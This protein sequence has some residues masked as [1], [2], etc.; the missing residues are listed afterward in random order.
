MK[1]LFIIGLI[2]FVTSCHSHKHCATSDK[3][4]CEKTCEKKCETSDK[5][6]C[7]KSCTTTTTESCC[8]K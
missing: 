6:T 8:T 1:K 7:A 5:K 3:T 2:L 4:K